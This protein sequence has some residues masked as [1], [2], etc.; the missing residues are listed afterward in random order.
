MIKINTCDFH[1]IKPLVKTNNEIS[2]LSVINGTMPGEIYVNSIDYP[3][4]ALIKTCECNLI[5]G[6]TADIKFNSEVSSELDFWDQLTP[7]S[8]EW[9][10]IIPAIHKNPFIRKYKRRH[11]T[12]TVTDFMECTIPLKDGFMLEKVNTELLRKNSLINSDKLL[13]WIS[14]WG[15]DNNFY[16]Y[17]VG[18]FIHNE[19][20]IISWSLSDCCLD[21][22]ITI[23]VHTDERYR[24]NGF[25]KMV[26]SSIV[27]ECF[28]KG[29]EK[30]NWLCVDT[31]KGSAALAESLGFQLHNTYYSFSSYPPIENVTDL[32]ESEWLEWGEYLENASQTIDMLI[33]ESLY[34]YIKANN[35]EKT[36]Q[37]MTSME[38]NQIGLDY[39]KFIGFITYLQELGLCSNFSSPIWLDFIHK[40]V[41]K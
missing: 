31:N 26:V 33:W 23:G 34:C 10:D 1:K 14:D 7:G 37:I 38:H 30:I 8:K 20:E 28:S 9:I 29:Y 11:Y 41:S 5:T 13:D 19:K 35:V 16:Q 25:G 18:F 27:K 17:G 3:S 6:D 40:R 32:S 15:D 4:V 39:I 21:K 2:V 22:Q 12:L 36:I 24:K